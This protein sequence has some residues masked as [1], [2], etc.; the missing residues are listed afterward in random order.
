[1]YVLHLTDESIKDFN[2]ELVSDR[3]ETRYSRAGGIESVK[4]LNAVH[5]L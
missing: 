5:E 2:R 3:E 4:R 1:M